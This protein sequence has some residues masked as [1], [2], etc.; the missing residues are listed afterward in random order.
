[1]PGLIVFIGCLSALNLWLT[2]RVLRAPDEHL[3]KKWLLVAGIWVAPAI[4]AW[5]AWDQLRA[6]VPGVDA[7]PSGPNR[8]PGRVRWRRASPPLRA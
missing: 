8:R 4:G 7:R 5:L 6:R 3:D 1:M 2:R